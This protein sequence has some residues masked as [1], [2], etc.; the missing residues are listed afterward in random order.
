MTKSKIPEIFQ[1]KK[2]L[3]PTYD[4]AFK[5]FFDSEDALKSFINGVMHL[6]G[7]KRIE[8][9]TYRI[10]Q[11]ML[12]RVPE[13]MTYRFDISATTANGENIDIE[14]QRAKHSFFFDRMVIYNAMQTIKGKKEFDKKRTQM[15]YL[16][17]KHYLYKLPS[18]IAIWICD[19]ELIEGTDFLDEINLHSKNHLKK[20][21]YEPITTVNKYI[22]VELPK[23]NKAVDQLTSA[24]DY[25][26]YLIKNLGKT[27]KSLDIDDSIFKEALARIEV[28][29]SNME[30]LTLQEK[31]M[32]DE[33]EYQ[34]CI[35]D[36][37]IT[38][39]EQGFEQGHAE[40]LAKGHADGLAKGLAEGHAE[41]LVEGSLVK[42]HEIAKSMLI[43]GLPIS[44][45]M[46]YSGLSEEEIKKLKE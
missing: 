6:E 16:Q 9:L 28:S 24:E 38:G 15:D 43:D 39:R 26:F 3:D 4:P 32:R 35:A 30:L 40:G 7:E 14:M 1:G 36:A 31:N 5:A 45:I 23:F 22:L 8:H 2:Y 13:E 11:N 25:W 29:E 21:D 44:K 42:A 12:F 17:S 41:G 10:E 20:G 33:R 27:G 37:I 19:F 18:S 46:S 34:C